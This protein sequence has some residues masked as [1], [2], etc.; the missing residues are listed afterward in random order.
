MGGMMMSKTTL[1]N[2]VIKPAFLVFGP[3]AVN[4]IPT[5]TAGMQSNHIIKS[6]ISISIFI[7]L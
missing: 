6:I 2:K 1:A 4:I 3:T 5:I 7:V